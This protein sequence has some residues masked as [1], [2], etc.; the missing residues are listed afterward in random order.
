MLR[1]VSLMT[2]LGIT[3]GHSDIHRNEEADALARAGLS[4]AFV[5]LRLEH[6]LPLVSSSVTRREWGGYLNHSAPHRT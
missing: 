2:C 5:G 6:C 3:G 1:K 4:S